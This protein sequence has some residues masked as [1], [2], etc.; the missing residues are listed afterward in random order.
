MIIPMKSKLDIYYKLIDRKV[1]KALD[2]IDWSVWFQSA[3]R[4]IKHTDIRNN[5]SVS[6][7]FLGIDHDLFNNKP[8]LFETMVFGGKFDQLQK[9][10]ISI[11]EAE[12]GHDKIVEL[13]KSQFIHLSDKHKKN[14]YV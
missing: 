4:K 2:L 6:T 8:V 7:V 3:D 12:Q 9:R 10:Y 5:V 14:N 13:C 1:L 11:E